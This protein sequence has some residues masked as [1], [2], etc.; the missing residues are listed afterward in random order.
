MFIIY[1]L[2]PYEILV[3]YSFEFTFGQQVHI[4][5]FSAALTHNL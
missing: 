3:T 1:I 5:A 4:A 2:D